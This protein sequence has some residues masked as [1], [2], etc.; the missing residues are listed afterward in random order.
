MDLCLIMS[1]I[2]DNEIEAEVFE[3]FIC[4]I[5]VFLVNQ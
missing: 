5:F 2:F 4:I 3:M 1:P